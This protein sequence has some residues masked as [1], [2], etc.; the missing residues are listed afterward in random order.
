MSDAPEIRR[1]DF[2]ESSL[3]LRALGVNDVRAFPFFE[4]PPPSAIDAAES[5][6]TQLGALEKNGAL[7]KIGQRLLTFPL[8]PRLAR[9]L[10]RT[11]GEHVGAT[12]KQIVLTTHNPLVLD[13]L[14]LANDDIRLFTVDRTEEGATA[15]R[16]V[17]HTEALRKAEASG[18]TMSQMW[19]DGLLGAVPSVW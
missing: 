1:L 13:G 8:H 17:E 11:L 18:A 14:A 2:V 7:T 19:L 5:L 10:I 16:R 15:I 6:L 4:P 9:A 12:G 3:S